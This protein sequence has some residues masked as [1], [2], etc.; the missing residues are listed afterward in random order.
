MPKTLTKTIMM[1]S[2]IF[3]MLFTPAIMTGPANL[4]KIANAIS[5]GDAA[6]LAGFFDKDVEMTVLDEINLYSK[7]EAQAAVKAFFTENPP[8][9]YTQVHQGASQ[10]AGGQYCI[11]VLETSAQKFRVMIYLEKVGE[12]F[13]IKEL[14]FEEE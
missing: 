5:E 14:K 8:K 9:K 12:N 1:K 11:G 13:L 7:A 2:I 4:A 10:G 3:L 6:A